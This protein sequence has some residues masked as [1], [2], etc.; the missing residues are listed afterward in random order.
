MT[1]P[2][3][4]YCCFEALQPLRPLIGLD[5]APFPCTL[6]RDRLPM[7][8]QEGQPMR[9]REFIAGLGSAAVW[10]LGLRRLL[11]TR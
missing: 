2:K 9:R 5:V 6:G 1:I 7:N 10:P 4:D 8:R 11:C 3:A